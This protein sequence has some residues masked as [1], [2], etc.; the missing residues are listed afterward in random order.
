MLPQAGITED[1][2]QTEM[3]QEGTGCTPSP[4]KLLLGFEFCRRSQGMVL[5]ETVFLIWKRVKVSSWSC[6]FQQL[7]AM[8]QAEPGA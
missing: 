8:L 7:G 5:W 2:C 4:F 6:V 3:S 1:A